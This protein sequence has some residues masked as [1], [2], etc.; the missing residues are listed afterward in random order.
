MR[1]GTAH[2]TVILSQEEIGSPFVLDP[3]AAIMMNQPSL[4]K[5]ELPT[6][7]CPV[8]IPARLA[9]TAQR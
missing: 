1:G 6:I 2:G 4:D 8:I 9:Q 7:H 3:Y 5:Y